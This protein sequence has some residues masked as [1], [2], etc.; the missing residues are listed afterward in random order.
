M[1]GVNV[2]Q[3][4]VSLF[5]SRDVQLFEEREFSRIEEL[6]RVDAIGDESETLLGR[7]N[8]AKDRSSR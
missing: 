2:A 5:F 4:F 1:Y 3:I 7:K 6:T 8:F